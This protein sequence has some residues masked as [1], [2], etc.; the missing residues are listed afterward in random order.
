MNLTFTPA[1]PESYDD[2]KRLVDALEPEQMHEMISRPSSAP[3]GG[4]E[5]PCIIKACYLDPELLTAAQRL[6]DELR[7]KSDEIS[8]KRKPVYI[9][10][11]SKA[12]AVKQY[13]P[14]F[15]E[16]YAKGKDYDPDRERAEERRLKRQIRK[17][18]RGAIRELRKDA[19]FM[20]GVRDEEKRR[21]QTRLTTVRNEPYPS[22]SSKSLI[23]RVEA[24]GDV[25]KE[26]EEIIYT[27]L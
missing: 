6:A 11:I 25:E 2:F 5:C 22:S 7:D 14:R 15:E 8:S 24:K 1:L 21:L 19:V 9:S 10:S 18:E 12:P 27:K 13:N 16:S 3:A 4:V 17:E 20:A 26:K 23:S